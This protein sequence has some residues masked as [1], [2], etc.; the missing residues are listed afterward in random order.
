MATPMSADR[1]VCQHSWFQRQN[2][3]YRF[4]SQWPVR[5]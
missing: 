5:H 3:L 2:F 1:L 4:L